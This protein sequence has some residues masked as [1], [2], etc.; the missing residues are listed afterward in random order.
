[1]TFTAN[2][3]YVRE[4]AQ[5]YAQQNAMVHIGKDEV[6]TWLASKPLLRRLFALRTLMF[7]WRARR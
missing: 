2:P 7:R 5:A 4:L 3:A 1:M 6:K